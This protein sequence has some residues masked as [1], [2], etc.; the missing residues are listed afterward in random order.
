[1]LQLPRHKSTFTPYIFSRDQIAAV[2]AACD[3]LRSKK[4]EWTRQLLLFLR[5][6]GYCM[7][8][9]YV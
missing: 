5:F 7:Q 1:M 6:F 9:V 2:F 3:A 8:L 4:K